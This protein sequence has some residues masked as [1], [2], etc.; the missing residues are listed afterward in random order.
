MISNISPSIESLDENISTL[1]YS[2]KASIIKN[3]PEKNIDPKIALINELK[4]N[5]N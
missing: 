5:L 2:S 1:N 4:V 3:N